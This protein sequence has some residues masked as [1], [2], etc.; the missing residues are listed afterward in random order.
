MGPILAVFKS[1]RAPL[2]RGS[3]LNKKVCVMSLAISRYE[4]FFD[5]VAPA[6]L[7]GLGLASA[8]AFA[9]LGA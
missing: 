9:V 1:Q 5:R 6:L 3:S 4:R 2:P 8:A 7:L